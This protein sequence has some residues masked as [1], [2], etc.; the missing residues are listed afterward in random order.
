MVTPSIRQCTTPTLTDSQFAML[1]DM[2]EE[3]RRFRIEQLTATADTQRAMTEADLEVQETILHGA[4]LA[5]TE[6]ESA[7]DRMSRGAYGRCTQCGSRLP[8]ERLEIL[9]QAAH[10]MPC[11][12]REDARR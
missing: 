7:L 2:L 8:L 9:P 6:L 11:Q 12:R 3:Q 5:L 10:C 1:H 4:R